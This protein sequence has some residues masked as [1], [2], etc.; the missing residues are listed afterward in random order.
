MDDW[1]EIVKVLRGGRLIDGESFERKYRTVS[2]LELEP[3]FY[4]VTW[5]RSA[6]RRE[7][8]EHARFFGPYRR[9]E[10]A[11]AVLERRRG[12]HTGCGA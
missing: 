9:R 4:V 5:L 6:E 8:D 2:G 7:Y 1:S 12:G 11:R 3:G 10:Q